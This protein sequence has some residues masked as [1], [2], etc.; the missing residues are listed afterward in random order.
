MEMHHDRCEEGLDTVGSER[1]AF[2]A[3]F[4]HTDAG[5]IEWVH[6]LSL[7]D[8]GTAGLGQ[9]N[10][11]DPEHLAYVIPCIV[12]TQSSRRWRTAAGPRSVR[13]RP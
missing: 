11:V 5:G 8:E 10:P 9:S 6:H 3:T 2:E 13:P 7:H 4:R 12:D 1:M